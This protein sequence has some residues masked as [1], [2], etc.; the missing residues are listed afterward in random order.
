M[1]T[2]NTT[3]TELKQNASPKTIKYAEKIEKTSTVVNETPVA[4]IIT[5]L[6][7]KI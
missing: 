7:P 5:T 1:D 3:A 2:A 4:T 6:T